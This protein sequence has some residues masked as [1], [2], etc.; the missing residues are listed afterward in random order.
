MDGMIN[1]HYASSAEVNPYFS[2][3]GFWNILRAAN[4]Q[5]MLFILRV[6]PKTRGEI[7]EKSGYNIYDKKNLFKLLVYV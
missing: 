5:R 3:I 7:H 2:S 4:Y 6:L 1:Y